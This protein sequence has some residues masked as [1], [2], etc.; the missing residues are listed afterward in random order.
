MHLATA[1]AHLAQ[2][3]AEDYLQFAGY[4]H[5]CGKPETKTNKTM[6]G[7][8]TDNFHYYSHE[9]VGSYKALFFAK[10]EGFSDSDILKISQ[11]VRFHMRPYFAETPKAI[12]KL[13]SQIGD[14]YEDLQTLH[15][16][17]VSAH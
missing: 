2:D 8:V 16:A 11:L 17:D 10:V 7:E 14:L 1:G 9:M 6:K 12:A 4:L 3:G 5:D 15:E 13:K